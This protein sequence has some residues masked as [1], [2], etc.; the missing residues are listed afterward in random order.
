[1]QGFSASLGWCCRSHCESII[2]PGMTQTHAHTCMHAHAHINVYTSTT[3]YCI[4]Y[5][6]PQDLDQAEHKKTSQHD[7]IEWWK[8]RKLWK[9]FWADINY[10]WLRM[11][12]Q[13]SFIVLADHTRVD[14]SKRSL[15]ST[16]RKHSYT[17]THTCTH[18]RCIRM[19]ITP[20]LCISEAT[21]INE[22][23]RWK[24]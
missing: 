8:F 19:M 4:V 13:H 21:M 7:I 15:C 11:L 9:G 16:H 24:G 20:V 3:R 17:H 18:R 10:G 6:G 1:M 12:C 23:V 5:L 14:S 22:T 2:I